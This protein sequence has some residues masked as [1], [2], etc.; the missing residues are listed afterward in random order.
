MISEKSGSIYEPQGIRE[1]REGQTARQCGP[2][3]DGVSIL[4]PES[5]EQ[6]IRMARSELAEKQM[7][8]AGLEQ[9]RGRAFS[10]L[11]KIPE[12]E[13]DK[14]EQFFSLYDEIKREIKSVQGQ[15][16]VLA[17][18]LEELEQERL[19]IPEDAYREGPKPGA[20]EK[21]GPFDFHR[22]RRK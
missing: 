12:S 18:M 4:V 14:K 16:A 5:I 11:Q 1:I 13:R 19:V 6:K 15:I 10:V 2:A 9:E 17:E 20:S 7:K 21:T 3:S 22:Q 8:L